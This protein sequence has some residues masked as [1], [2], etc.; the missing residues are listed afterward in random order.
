MGQKRFTPEQIIGKLRHISTTMRYAEIHPEYSD[1]RSY[2][3]RVEE[4]FGLSSG[5]SLGHTPLQEEAG[6][7]RRNV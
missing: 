5:P 3:D 6:V 1:V 4:K 7:V 2:F